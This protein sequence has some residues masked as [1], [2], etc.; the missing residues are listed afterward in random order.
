M[1]ALRAALLRKQTGGSLRRFAQLL[2]HS[3]LYQWFCQINRFST[4]KIPGKSTIDDYEKKIGPSLSDA[5]DQCLLQLAS[6]PGE[7][8]DD[9]I[10]LSECF[11]DT[12]C[13]QAN[14]HFPVDWVL[15]RDAI[16]T[17]M[18]AVGRIRDRYQCQM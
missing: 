17:L 10:D 18:L 5:L 2:S 9:P 14:I 3:P 1:V 13:V 15:I 16:R 12:T 11:M 7:L 8:L 4:I 6:Q